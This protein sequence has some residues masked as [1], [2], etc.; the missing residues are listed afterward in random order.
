MVYPN[1]S[2]DLVF[3]QSEEKI[4]NISVKNMAGQTVQI[5]HQKNIQSVDI[6]GLVEGMYI[7]EMKDHKGDH[8]FQK[9]IKK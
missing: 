8:S 6:S 3:I 2:S 1:P 7:L 9:L 5:I 4:S